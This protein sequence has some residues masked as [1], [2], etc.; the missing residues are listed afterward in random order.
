MPDHSDVLLDDVSARDDEDDDPWA[1]VLY[2]TSCRGSDESGD[3][4]W[5]CERLPV[6]AEVEDD[7]SPGS[8]S[9]SHEG[10]FLPLRDE[11]VKKAN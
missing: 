9:S 4:G 6:L 10:R 5:R 8:V 3:T 2:G 7:V 11:S 1:T